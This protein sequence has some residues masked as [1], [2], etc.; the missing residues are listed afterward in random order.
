MS[1][2]RHVPTALDP[3]LP[4]SHA[5]VS[6]A[7]VHIGKHRVHNRECKKVEEGGGDARKWRNEAREEQFWVKLLQ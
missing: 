3:A 1:S 7:A 6:R 4:P 2:P 5:S